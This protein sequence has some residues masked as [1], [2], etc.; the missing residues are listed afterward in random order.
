MKKTRLKFE[1]TLSR[2]I[3]LKEREALMGAL[4]AQCEEVEVKGVQVAVGYD[5]GTANFETTNIEDSNELKPL[6]VDNK[7]SPLF[8]DPDYDKPCNPWS[9]RNPKDD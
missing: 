7:T 3:S 8:D 2:S 1:I 6:K 4:I 9:G 5:W